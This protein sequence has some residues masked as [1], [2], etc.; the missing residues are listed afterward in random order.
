LIIN[1]ARYMDACW[2]YARVNRPGHWLPLV[3]PDA[4]ADLAIDWLDGSVTGRCGLALAL[5]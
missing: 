3:A 4:V 2:R 1:S 5:S